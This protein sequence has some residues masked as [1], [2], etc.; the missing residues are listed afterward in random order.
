[1]VFL[2]TR[3]PEE[4][5]IPE[6]CRSRSDHPSTLYPHKEITISKQIVVQTDVGLSTLLKG[7]YRTEQIIYNEEEGF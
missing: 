1:M 4:G 2:F 7:R 5:L 6:T 3:S